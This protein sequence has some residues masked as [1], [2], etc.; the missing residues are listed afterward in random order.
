MSV[1]LQR[2]SPFLAQSFVLA[3]NSLSV[4]ESDKLPYPNVGLFSTQL[5]LRPPT[6]CLCLRTSDCLVG[7]P[8]RAIPLLPRER[9]RFFTSTSFAEHVRDVVVSPPPSPPLPV[10][11]FLSI[12]LP[13]RLPAT[14]WQ[15]VLF[16]DKPQLPVAP[17][18]HSSP[19]QREG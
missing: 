3:L 19:L 1:S 5:Q 10:H 4:C 15:D 11:V 8:N 17:S 14:L 2:L 16:R 18:G 13:I 7:G 6:S 9:S 12:S